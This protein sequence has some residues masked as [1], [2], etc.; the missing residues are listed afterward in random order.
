[1]LT[2]LVRGLV[3]CALLGFGSCAYSGMGEVR[4]FTCT[5]SS[6]VC[7]L[8]SE[9]RHEPTVRFPVDDLTGAE[10]EDYRTTHP[11]APGNRSGKSERLVL[12]TKGGRVPLMAEY[13]GID[14]DEMAVQKA[15]VDA[16]VRLR[17][18]PELRIR[19]DERRLAAVIGGIP[20]LLGLGCL[21]SAVLE[22]RRWRDA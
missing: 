12:L 7:I 13:S 10:V 1:M 15:E 5:R 6:G 18:R 17:D 3:A 22:Y 14:M 21:V 8:E 20:F 16:F 19:R 11:N 2:V 9:S 4:T